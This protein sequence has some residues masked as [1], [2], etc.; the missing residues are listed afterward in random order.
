[1]LLKIGMKLCTYNIHYSAQNKK[2]LSNFQPNFQEKLTDPS[3]SSKV[4]CFKKLSVN[5][6]YL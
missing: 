3:L 4:G 5:V 6:I 2:L 1:M